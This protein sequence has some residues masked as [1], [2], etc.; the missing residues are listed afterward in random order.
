[1]NWREPIRND[2]R[3]TTEDEERSGSHGPRHNAT[4]GM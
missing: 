2:T 1:V 4:S 3:T